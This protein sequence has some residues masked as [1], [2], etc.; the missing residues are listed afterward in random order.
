MYQ[1]NTFLHQALLR[2]SSFCILFILLPVSHAIAQDL[3]E[4][5]LGEWNMVSNGDGFLEATILFDQDHGYQL[6]RRWPD[7][8]AAGIKGS[9][10]LDSKRSPA[11]LKLCLGDCNAAGSEWTTM[12]C[13]TRM[14]G[15]DRLEIMF[16]DSGEFPGEFP[17]DPGSKGMYV[18]NRME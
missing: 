15:A 2:V 14:K 18:F 1:K 11:T 4:T 3:E 16:S 6:D 12:F 8:S 17:S 10:E 7:G 13:I 5:I 9:Y